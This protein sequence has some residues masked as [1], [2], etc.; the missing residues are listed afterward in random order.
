MKKK[1]ALTPAALDALHDGFLS[2]LLTPGLLIEARASGKKRWRFRRLIA[3]T[4]VIASVYGGLY[5]ATTIA[6]AREWGRALNE[7]V[8]AGVDPR[9]AIRER[10]VRDAMTSA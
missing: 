1:N 5:P 10:K 4:T 2:D 8:E 3:G 6:E 7:C 9:E